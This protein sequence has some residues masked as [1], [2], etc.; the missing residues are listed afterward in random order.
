[1]LKHKPALLVED[2]KYCPG[3]GHG[4]INRLVAEVLEEMGL[5]KKAIGA[6][7][8]GCAC[9]MIDTFG[10]DWIQA[11]HGRAAA[12]ACGIKRCRPE[13][14]V[15][16]Y[17]GDGDA[18][19]IGLAETLYAAIRNEK[20]TVILVNNSVFGMTGGQMSPCTL[21]GQRTT[22]SPYGRDVTLAGEPVNVVEFLKT[23][24][25]AYLARGSVTS[26]AA[27]NRTKRYIRNA[28]EAQMAGEGYSFVEVV[29]PCPTNWGVTPLKALEHIEKNVLQVYPTGEFIKRGG[30]QVG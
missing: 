15:F 16:T 24:N 2:N 11:M 21:E 5:Q 7:A 10:V 29:S 9:L 18:L 3:C 28:F 14:P 27:I 4:I 30:V 23:R 13:N 17:Q 26:P 22:T 20:I 12:V 19:A 8:V 25:I 1:M 6:V